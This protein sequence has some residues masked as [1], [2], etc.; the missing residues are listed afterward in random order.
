LKL[1]VSIA[2]GFL[3]LFARAGQL[4]AKAT[5]FA[6]SADSVPFLGDKDVPRG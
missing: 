2:G 3:L 6:T 4:A 1:V 5:F